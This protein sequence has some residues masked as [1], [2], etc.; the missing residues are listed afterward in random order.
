MQADTIPCVEH[1][2]RSSEAFYGAP[3][4]LPADIN[5]DM[6]LIENAT[7][8]EWMLP[9]VMLG[10]FFFTVAW[11]SFSPR[12]KQNMQAVFSSRFFNLVDKERSF[13]LETP[14]FLLFVNFLLTL[15]L[16]MYQTLQFY[17]FLLIST[18]KH[19][20][21]EYAVILLAVILFYPLK[22]MLI[23][24]L[25]WVFGTQRASYL[26]VENMLLA[27]NF[28]GLVLLPLVFYNAFNPALE[29]LILMWGII[30]TINVYKMIRG[31]YLAH[32]E[33]GFSTYYLFL[34]LCAVEIAPLIIIG[35]AVTTYLPGISG[36]IVSY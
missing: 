3:H 16:L 6:I 2:I 17:D 28:I 1:S 11:Y 13:L 12:I 35:K 22:L 18:T 9:V 25:A 32:G 27:N 4:Y 7:V 29:L 26:Y 8:N 14:T 33:S 31:A 23:G 21:F 30:I 19:P 24:F 15:S 34:Y 5:R 10:L 36:G 20:V